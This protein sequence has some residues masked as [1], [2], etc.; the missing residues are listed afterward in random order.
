MAAGRAKHIGALGWD[1]P[2]THPMIGISAVAITLQSRRVSKSA[3]CTFLWLEC[4][5]RLLARKIAKTTSTAQAAGIFK[6]K[7]LPTALTFK[8][9]HGTPER[10]MAACHRRLTRIFERR[11]GF[12][13]ANI[14][15]G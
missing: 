1:E 13:K 9:L 8:K 7:H 5:H 15:L 14:L 2:I 11:K 3:P 12:S 10:M 6:I 4:R